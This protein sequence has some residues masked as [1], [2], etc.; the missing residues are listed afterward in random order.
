MET[1]KKVTDLPSGS[2][3]E[4]YIELRDR[5][6]KRKAEYENADAADKGKQEKL[7][8]ILLSRFNAEGITAINAPSGTAY[9]STRTSARVA[10][11]DVFL[12]WIKETENWGFLDIKANKTNVAQYRSEQEILPPGLNWTEELTVNVRRS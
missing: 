7:E 11:K 6:A 1:K 8:G 2:L 5:R 4:I 9:T 3:V 10:D 12:T